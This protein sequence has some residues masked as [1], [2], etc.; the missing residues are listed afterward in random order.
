MAL[1]DPH[2]HCRHVPMLLY[3]IVTIERDPRNS[4]FLSGK[5]LEVRIQSKTGPSVGRKTDE[6]YK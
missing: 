5:Q 2:R 6:V 4:I 1:G 3:S